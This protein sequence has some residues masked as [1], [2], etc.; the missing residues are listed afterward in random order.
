MFELTGIFVDVI[1]IVTFQQ[2]DAA[3]R[4]GFRPPEPWRR[5]GGI[6]SVPQIRRQPDLRKPG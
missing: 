1:R 6:G 3:R 4:H 5:D 2:T